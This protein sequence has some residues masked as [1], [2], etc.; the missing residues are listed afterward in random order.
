[1]TRVI[2][3][4]V[5]V[6]NHDRS[7]VQPIRNNAINVVLYDILP[8]YVEVAEIAKVGKSIH[9]RSKSNSNSKVE[10]ND[11]NKEFFVV[12]DDKNKQGTK[13]GQ[14]IHCTL[15]HGRNQLFK[16]CQSAN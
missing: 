12:D 10:D 15:N 7:S 2:D 4:T 16:S 13:N 6:N 1:M 9:H 11:V 5:S 8:E 3:V 14:K